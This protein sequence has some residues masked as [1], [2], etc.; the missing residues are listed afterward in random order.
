MSNSNLIELENLM[1]KHGITLQAIEKI[2]P[3][4]YEPSMNLSI[5][6]VPARV[7]FYW[8]K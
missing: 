4:L 6:G 7:Y 3:K 8:K 1:S 5:T 2:Y